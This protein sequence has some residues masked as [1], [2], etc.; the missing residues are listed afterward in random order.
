M[1]CYTRELLGWRLSRTGNAKVA[2]AALEEYLISRYGF[3]SR[4]EDDLI[5]RSDNG[6]VFCNRRYTQTV[7]RYDIKQEFV[8]PHTP[9]KNGMVERL[10]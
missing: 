8:R 2:E 10:I 1:D 7:Y 5:I 6:L 4:A 3:L 9:Q